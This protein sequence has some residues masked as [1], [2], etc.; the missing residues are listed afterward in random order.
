MDAKQKKL[1]IIQQILQVEDPNVLDTIWQLLRLNETSSHTPPKLEQ[2]P[3]LELLDG[4]KGNNLDED[5]QDLQQ[6]I[7]D[8]FG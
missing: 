3:L 4:E 2:D 6:S 7:D 5:A 1:A 8:I